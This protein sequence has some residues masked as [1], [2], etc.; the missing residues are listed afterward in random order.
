MEIIGSLILDPSVC[1]CVCVS[2]WCGD[3]MMIRCRCHPYPEYRVLETEPSKPRVV[4]VKAKKYA[5]RL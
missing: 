4:S 5:C 1:V 2:E 3:V